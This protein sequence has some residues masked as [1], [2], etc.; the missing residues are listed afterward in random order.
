MDDR[1]EEIDEDEQL[2]IAI[3]LSLEDQKVLEAAQEPPTVEKDHDSLRR[4]GSSNV[5]DCI[6]ATDLVSPKKPNGALV[7]NSE[8]KSPSPNNAGSSLGL[9]GLN[10]KAMEAERLARKRKA[11]ATV[12]SENAEIEPGSK[13]PNT[14]RQRI[15][16]ESNK[17]P[18]NQML[19]ST[20]PS[21]INPLPPRQSHPKYLTGAV[22]KT[23]SFGHSRSKDIKIEEVLEKSDLQLAVLSAFQWDIAWIFDKLSLSK[24]KLYLVMQAK[25]E[26]QQVE[27]RDEVS[28]L[29]TVRLVFP[30]MP[31]NVH[32][33]HSKL[34]LL[35][36]PTYLR[37]VVPTANLVPYDWGETGVLENTI[38]LI[39]LPR[40]PDGKLTSDEEMTSFGKSLIHFCTALTLPDAP[41]SSLRKFDFS[42]TKDIA[43]VHSIGG[44]HTSS[45]A[46][47]RTGY[48]GFAT[49]I[50]DLGLATNRPLKIDYITSS[51][52]ASYMDLFSTIYLTCQGSEGIK[53]YEWRYNTPRA[54]KSKDPMNPYAEEQRSF[55]EEVRKNFSVYFPSLETVKES[56]GGKDNAGPI[57]FR[58]QWWN[59]PKFPRTVLRDCKSTR[60]GMLMHNKVRSV[61]SLILLSTVSK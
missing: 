21:I 8:R 22:K 34:M 45:S 42:A 57:C 11:E 46:W 16:E 58:S 61:S 38:F 3:A 25:E 48:P 55:V 27:W 31:G 56:K 5:I 24:T 29:P 54:K 47:K 2:R 37:I 43:F 19:L 1:Y 6:A 40:L 13:S 36:H 33:M 59:N 39:D 44:E 26:S 4:E 10:R 17:I 20:M 7:N 12:P 52:G 41:V 60:S 50:K 30:P 18:K 28:D 9:L 35:S 14:K 51:I 49:A 23:W 15:T 53:E 32:T